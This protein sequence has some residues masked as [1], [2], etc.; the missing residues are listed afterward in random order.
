M[1]GFTLKKTVRVAGKDYTV[2]IT[3]DREGPYHVYTAPSYDVEIRH[4][5]RQEAFKRLESELAAAV[6]AFVKSRI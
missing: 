4:L 5:D 1:P 3:Y 6:Q 2:P